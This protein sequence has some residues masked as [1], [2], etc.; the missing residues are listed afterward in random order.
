MRRGERLMSD[1]EPFHLLLEFVRAEDAADRHAAQAGRWNEYLLR[2]PDGSGRYVQGSFKWSTEVQEA[3]AALERPANLE[4]AVERLTAPLQAFVAATCWSSYEA[5]ALEAI[6]GG[7]PVVITVRSAAAELFALPWELLPLGGVPAAQHPA[8]LVRY[9][10]PDDALVLRALDAMDDPL[11]RTEPEAAGRVV[12][13]WSAAAGAVPAAEHV[14]A[15]RAAL[16]RAD[17][18]PEQ[19]LLVLPNVTAQ[20][21]REAL[22]DPEVQVVHL[23]AHGA[24]VAGG[25]AFG[26]ALDPGE[27]P[28]R[29]HVLSPDELGALVREE[30][31]HLRM[32]AVLACHGGNVGGL[33]NRV[34]SLAQALSRAGVTTVLASRY[35]LSVKGSVRVSERLYRGLLV[36]LQSVEQAV[37]AARQAEHELPDSFD[38]AALQL[39]AHVERGAHARPMVFRPYRGLLPFRAADSRWFFGRDEERRDLLAM[40]DGLLSSSRHRFLLVAGASGSGKSSLVSAGLV[41]DL[42]CRAENTGWRALTMRPGASREPAQ[43]LEDLVAAASGA[44]P[45]LVLVDQFEELFNEVGEPEARTRFLRALWELGR[46][47]SPRTVLVL[48]TI[49][50]EYLGH[51]GDHAIEPAQGRF[52]RIVFDDHHRYFVPQL[53]PGQV[54]Q[55]VRGPAERLGL[56][57]EDGLVERLVGDVGAEPGALPLLSYALDLL[58]QHRRGA[59]L[60]DLTYDALGGVSGALTRSAEKVHERIGE[61]PQGQARQQQLRNLLVRIVHPHEDPALS[62]RRR[63][64][65]AD[66]RPAE[67]QDAAAFDAALDAFVQARLL[68]TSGEGTEGTVEVAHESLIRHW[69]RL[70]TWLQGDAEWLRFADEL[71]EHARDWAN[72]GRSTEYVYRGARLGYAM[73]LFERYGGRFGARERATIDAF[74]LASNRAALRRQ[75]QILY[76]AAALTTIALVGG[77]WSYAASVSA[78]VGRQRADDANVIAAARVATEEGRD[79]LAARLLRDVR[80]PQDQTGWV[81]AASDVLRRG[82]PAWEQHDEMSLIGVVEVRGHLAVQYADGAVLL[83]PHEAPEAIEQLVEAGDFLAPGTLSGS[84]SADHVLSVWNGEATAFPLDGREGVALRVDE[85]AEIL[86]GALSGDGRRA[87][88]VTAESLY[89]F[90]TTTGT[91]LR[92]SALSGRVTAVALS[93]DGERAA[94]AFHDGQLALVDARGEQ[95]RMHN[96]HTATEP[97]PSAFDPMMDPAIQLQLLAAELAPRPD[98]PP[99]AWF[100]DL[101]FDGGPCPTVLD[102]SVERWTWSAPDCDGDAQPAP[103]AAGSSRVSFVTDE[104]GVTVFPRGPG[105]RDRWTLPLRGVDRRPRG[106]L[107]SDGR[108]VVVWGGEAAGISSSV[109]R[110]LTLDDPNRAVELRGVP[111]HGENPAGGALPDWHLVRSHD[112]LRLWDANSGRIEQFRPDPTQP[113]RVINDPALA[114]S[115]LLDVA[116]DGTSQ[117]HCERR[118][119]AEPC[120]RIVWRSATTELLLAE[121]LHPHDVYGRL[122]PDGT[123]LIWGVLGAPNPVWLYTLGAGPRA[124]GPGPLRS[125]SWSAD[126]HRAG[127]VG[128]DGRV[129][130][131]DGEADHPLGVLAGQAIT[132]EAAWFHLVLSGD[133]S[134]LVASSGA[135]SGLAIWDLGAGLHAREPDLFPHT[136]DAEVL[137]LSHDGAR[138]AAARL[139]DVHLYYTGEE[140]PYLTLDGAA[141]TTGVFPAA[142]F[143]DDGARLA[144]LSGSPTHP[145][146]H[147]YDLS[148]DVRTMVQSLHQL[149]R[150]CVPPEITMRVLGDTEP[151]ALDREQRCLDA[152]AR[153]FD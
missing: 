40:V 152:Q 19:H 147:L 44:G 46:P 41:P 103:S 123:R 36:D 94:L 39:Y 106:L 86:D 61:G 116:G 137:A 127:W 107:T 122:S 81:D 115:A 71:G 96:P 60:R 59:W 87:V 5:L 113:V 150:G 146:V 141:W 109:V 8:V 33:D 12:L 80:R 2:E 90:D 21:L 67:Q 32:A 92:R 77:A 52:D 55:A 66:L 142:A 143:V 95:R 130:V 38:W 68:V 10:W 91:E 70:Q 26:L 138:L 62:T 37:V 48:G 18:D 75:R 22:R 100:L 58:W 151:H 56:R 35:P 82:V 149:S 4:E 24:M 54:E 3:L 16:E 78:E 131:V 126:G 11:A 15:V 83:A 28:A 114:P 43:L 145:G 88:L 140:Q 63:L 74:L 45:L 112:D 135:M 129:T 30:V 99:A 125:A 120:R 93:S 13:A 29:T 85:D 76:G 79:G 108:W 101:R 57:F 69:T 49:R 31:G 53:A 1:T 134:R 128:A 136:P 148:D 42:L 111:L 72:N 50:L 139:D 84:P 118:D 25:A 121:H 105:S 132:E 124:R 9:D 102:R 34:G 110:W 7:R 119:R 133:G 51:F 14:R 117:L 64:P 27:P 97:A 47:Q 153:T 104:A 23:L 6:G 20:R 98:K 73:T 144:V 65:M 89:L 17:L